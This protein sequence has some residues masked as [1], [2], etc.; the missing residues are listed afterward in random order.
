M[1]MIHKEGELDIAKR[2]H[3]LDNLDAD[4]SFH[5]DYFL[6]ISKSC[7]NKAPQTDLKDGRVKTNHAWMPLKAGVF[8]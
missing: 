6:F 5:R 8:K 4:N 1:M 2:R 7:H 3:C